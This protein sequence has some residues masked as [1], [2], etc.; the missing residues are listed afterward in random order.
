M[1][2]L[3]EGDVISVSVGYTRA[4]GTFEAPRVVICRK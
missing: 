3:K 4:E 1:S 2:Q